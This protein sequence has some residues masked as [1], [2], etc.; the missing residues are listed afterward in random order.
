MIK[1]FKTN[2]SQKNFCE[3][4][5]LIILFLEHLSSVLN[6]NGETDALAFLEFRY[7]HSL[8]KCHFRIEL[9][10]NQYFIIINYGIFI[11]SLFKALSEGYLW[12]VHI[13]TRGCKSL[14]AREVN[15]ITRACPLD[16]YWY[17]IFHS[18]L[19]AWSIFPRC[20]TS[21]NAVLL[22]WKVF[23]NTDSNVD[24]AGL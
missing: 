6:W 23:V 18:C 15:I 1:A 17:N 24:H 11:N 12:V 20:T 5:V 9:Q 10:M 14:N 7:N 13:R 3:S 19:S 16:I 8:L 4:F 2:K 21:N 22:K